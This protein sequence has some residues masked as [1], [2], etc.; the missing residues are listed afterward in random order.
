MANSTPEKSGGIQQRVL[1]AVL[2][3]GTLAACFLGGMMLMRAD[4]GEMRPE[5]DGTIGQK[6]PVAEVGPK[7]VAMA[8]VP[9]AATPVQEPAA[10]P[11]QA[12]PAA[13][14]VQAV[15]PAAA[16]AVLMR[17]G[18]G[19]GTWDTTAQFK[20]ILVQGA[21]KKI[22]FKP[23]F[24]KG[25]L[26]W[27]MTQGQWDGVD[28]VLTQA[29]RLVGCRT[30]VGESTWS[31]YTYSLKAKRTDGTE[32]FLIVFAVQ[33]ARNL[34]W[35]NIGGWG[36]T[37]T[38]VERTMN[39]GKREIPG[40]AVNL[41]V[42]TEKWYDIRIELEGDTARCYFDGTLITTI[43]DGRGTSTLANAGPPQVFNNGDGPMPGRATVRPATN[44]APA[45]NPGPG[46]LNLPP[47]RFGSGPDPRRG[48]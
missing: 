25:T 12:A 20:E 43:A 5:E 14:D 6:T 7:A 44:P 39:G 10:Q 47:G 36:N 42:E 28:G 1:I 38:A 13:Q 27:E 33:D 24:A 34:F 35:W 9:E 29:S 37:R 46:T 48:G 3:T 2:G 4:S 22:L 31:D 40:T 18:I 11:A 16:R 15:R 45:A 26:G 8:V 21:D 32:G 17:G 30:T 41:K 23:D 19:M